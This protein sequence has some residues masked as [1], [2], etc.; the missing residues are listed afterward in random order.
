MRKMTAGA[1]HPL[2]IPLLVGW[3]WQITK[4]SNGGRRRVFY[5]GPCG[6]RLSSLEEVHKDINLTG[7]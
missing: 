3:D 4:H 1:L 7:L 5:V 2:L 6:R